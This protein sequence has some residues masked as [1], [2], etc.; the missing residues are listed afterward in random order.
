MSKQVLDG[1]STLLAL[2]AAIYGRLPASS[3]ASATSKGWAPLCRAAHEDMGEVPEMLEALGALNLHERAELLEDVLD[4]WAMG[5]PASQAEVVNRVLA[6]LGAPPVPGQND[7]VDALRQFG[8][9]VY[10]PDDLNLGDIDP[11]DLAENY[12]VLLARATP[13]GRDMPMLVLYPETEGAGIEDLERRTDWEHWGRYGKP[14]TNPAWRLRARITDRSLQGL[15]RVDPD[16]E[17]DDELWR[18]AETVSLPEHWWALLDR[19]RH[20]LVVG[21]VKDPDS[22]GAL[23]AAGDAGELLAVVVPV[24]FR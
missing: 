4:H 10:T 11:Y 1:E 6:H 14:D 13:D 22:P 3:V 5:G 19:V 20:V 18:A 24:D 2:A 12:G 17:V 21:P 9:G 15:V 8:V 16:G 7:L 23:Q